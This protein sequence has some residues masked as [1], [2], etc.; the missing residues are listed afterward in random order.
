VEEAFAAIERTGERIWEAEMY[1]LK[2]VFLLSD[3]PR[4]DEAERCFEKAIYIAHSQTTKSWELRATT[5][6]A[7]LWGQQGKR[8]EAHDLIAPA[9]NWFTEGFDTR[10][11]KEAK[12]LLAGLSA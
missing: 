4:V 1:R 6:L 10:D 9:Y 5:S 11:L 12:A 3:G 7:R 2:G 8:K